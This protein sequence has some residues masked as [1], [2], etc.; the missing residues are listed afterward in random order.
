MIGGGGLQFPEVRR[1]R[2]GTCEER[3]G[4]RWGVIESAGSVGEDGT[5]VGTDQG[6][7]TE[8]GVGQV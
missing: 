7:D 4:G 1:G 3:C 8:E 2:F 5:T 6:G